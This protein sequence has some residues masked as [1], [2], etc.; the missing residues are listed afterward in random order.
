MP[1]LVDK[2]ICTGCTACVSA[3]PKGCLTMESDDVGFLYP[4]LTDPQR[5]V[6][7]RLCERACPLLQKLPPLPKPKAYAAYTSDNS[8][9]AA[10]SSGGIFSELASEVLKERGA[11]FG[12]AYD[13]SFRVVHTCTEDEAGLAALRGAKYA[14]SDLRGIFA[15]VKKR[16]DLGQRVLFSGTPC[17]VGG[18]K[19]FLGRE[20]PAL[21]CVD[22]VCHGVPSPMAWEQY[23]AHM[24]QKG[25]IAAIDLRSK[26]TGWS[27]YRYSN[28]FTYKDGTQNVAS[29][30]ESLYMKLFVG[31]H[32]NRLSCQSCRFKGM[33]RISDITL[34]DFWGIWDIAPEMDDDR[35][36]SMVLVQSEKGRDIWAQI[37]PRLKCREVS[38]MD[39]VRKNPS[40]VVSSEASPL[41]SRVLSMIRGGQIGDCSTLLAQHSP[42]TVQKILRRVRKA[43]SLLLKKQ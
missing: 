5:C 37:S 17:Q 3:C 7:C 41:R 28:V 20:Y 36:T 21:L 15:D 25:P 14:Q 32:I 1:Q 38:G 40:A 16:L 13:G 42:G 26:E 2:N 4:E 24:A 22:F 6:E 11:V 33:G 19:A 43:L 23:V 35:G 10:S 39:A 18:L 30:G 12:A 9:R 34:G 31:D 8:I 29:S 27:R